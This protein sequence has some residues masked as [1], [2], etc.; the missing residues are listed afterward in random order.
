VIEAAMLIVV[1]KDRGAA[2]KR[3]ELVITDLI[4][5]LRR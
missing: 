5:G 3:S 2:R 1:A 4:E